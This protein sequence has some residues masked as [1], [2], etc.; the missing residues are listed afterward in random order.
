ML[1]TQLGADLFTLAMIKVAFEPH[2]NHQIV[3]SD[4]VG[5]DAFDYGICSVGYQFTRGVTTSGRAYP[6]RLMHI[7]CSMRDSSPLVLETLLYAHGPLADLATTGLFL[8]SYHYA[9]Q[10]KNYLYKVAVQ[11]MHLLPERR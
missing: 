1:F 9:A 5:H 6:Y 8:C 11:Y 4:A 10:I 7:E 3:T 2:P